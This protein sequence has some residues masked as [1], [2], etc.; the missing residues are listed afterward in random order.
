MGNRQRD[1]LTLTVVGSGTATPE[2]DRVCSG[3]FIETGDLRLLLDCG[4]GVVHH[5]ARYGLPWREITHVALTHFHN[6]HIGD[7]PFLFFAF[8]HG[9]L[10]PRSAPLTL[11]GPAGTAGRVAALADALGD[12]VRDPGFDVDV[13]TAANGA[14]IRLRDDATLRAYPTGHTEEAV[15]YRVETPA[16]VVG[17][18]GDTGENEALA[19]FLEGVD[20]LLIECSLPDERAIDSHLTP[21][22]VARMANRIRP[23]S[24]IV[25]HVYPLLDRTRVPHLIR[26]AGWTGDTRMAMDGLSFTLPL[27]VRGTG[28]SPP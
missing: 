28:R 26:T 13:R 22:R 4:P 1:R 27:P 9:M 8:R 25:T 12:H 11:I 23:A 21:A 5:L 16:G 19:A 7:L 10:P 6:D 20:L 3:Y 2:P 14:D 24:L 18:T 15:A 17:Y